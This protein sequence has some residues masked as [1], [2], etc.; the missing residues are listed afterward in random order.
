MIRKL[1]IQNF[2]GWQDTERI[3]L[4]P[5]TVLF[6][7]NSS[8]KSS[9]GHFLMMLKQSAASSDRKTIFYSGNDDS[10]VDV[11]LPKD[12][13]YKGDLKSGLKYYYQWDSSAFIIKLS[14]KKKEKID[15]V[16]IT[17][18]SEVAENEQNGSI[19]IK[20]MNYSVDSSMGI[21]SIG[22]ERSAKPQSNIRA[23]NVVEENYGLVR[24]LGRAWGCPAPIKFYGFP[25]EAVAYYQNAEILQELN[26]QQELLF[27]NIYYLGP[28]RKKASRL[29]VWDGSYPESVGSDGSQVVPAYLAAVKED[30]GDINFKPKGKTFTFENIIAMMLKKMGLVSDFKVESIAENRKEYD[31]KVKVKDYSE[32]TDILDVGTGISQVLPVIVELFYAPNGSTIIMEQP[33]LHLHPSAQAGLADVIIEAIH[34]RKNGQNR[35]IQLIIETHSEHFL[36]R[37]QRRIAEGALS[38][39]EFKAYFANNENE[40]A[41]LEP[42]QV[43]LFGDISNWPKEF[44]GD[45]SGDI[46]AQTKAALD[47][48][49]NEEK[50]NE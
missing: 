17:F 45:I 24:N 4:A 8:G 43:N 29:Y 30:N 25:D 3:D 33:E 13:F 48:R 14:N 5:L 16:S 31:V 47:A 12:Y 38:Q 18:E 49:I 34:S 32:W 28:L 22:M 42:L 6:G 35:N 39:E 26:L 2:K 21:F 41:V 46:F 40:K 15:F 50:I 10:I 36:R 27:S 7:T 11:G 19:E 9:I 44:F 20:K 23:Y 1:R 37:L